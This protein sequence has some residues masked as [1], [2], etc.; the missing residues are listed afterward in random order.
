MHERAIHATAHLDA[1]VS[2]LLVVA[3]L[4]TPV[5]LLREK[6]R[7]RRQVGSED[8]IDET[9]D[10]ARVA[11]PFHLAFQV[12]EADEHA[13]LADLERVAPGLRIDA[14]GEAT[15]VQLLL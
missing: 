12:V 14:K 3:R 10:A 8:R 6:C 11:I 9:C 4:Q 13:R 2:L 15:P 7:L 5:E 1:E